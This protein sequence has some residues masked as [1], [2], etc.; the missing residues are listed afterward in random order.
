[1]E[2]RRGAIAE[3]CRALKERFDLVFIDTE[4]DAASV[5][6]D[7]EAMAPLLISGGLAAFHDYPDPG[8][9]DVRRV[10]DE[11]AARHS[12]RRVAQADYLGVFRVGSGDDSKDQ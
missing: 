8:W 10:V 1:V 3:T 6:R 2:F 5:G 11:Y 7:I 9:P 12:W 4:H